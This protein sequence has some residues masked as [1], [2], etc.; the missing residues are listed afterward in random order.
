MFLKTCGGAKSAGRTSFDSGFDEAAETVTRSDESN[1]T[2]RVKN[3]RIL[4]ALNSGR[5][6]SELELEGYT[7]FRLS[8]CYQ[9]VWDYV[10]RSGMEATRSAG[11]DA[12]LV[13]VS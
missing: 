11:N 9:G 1:I 10:V 13:N 2:P 12:A 4:E 6:E 8:R 3:D 5:R 7:G